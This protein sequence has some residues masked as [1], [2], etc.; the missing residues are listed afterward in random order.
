METCFRSIVFFLSMHYVL[1]LF[2]DATGNYMIFLVLKP[3]SLCSGSEEAAADFRCEQPMVVFYGSEQLVAR[4]L[5]EQKDLF[6]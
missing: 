2:R 5:C 4:F 6:F 1:P 3:P